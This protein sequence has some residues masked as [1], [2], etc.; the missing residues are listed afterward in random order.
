MDLK[1]IWDEWVLQL[2]RRFNKTKY[3]L[4]LR[5]YYLFA[6]T[7]VFMRVFLFW[8]PQN[9][10]DLYFLIVFTMAK[11]P[12]GVMFV[13]NNLVYLS[14]ELPWTHDPGGRIRI[15]AVYGIWALLPSIA[16]DRNRD[17]F[18]PILYFR[19]KHIKIHHCTY[20]ECFYWHELLSGDK[21]AAA[22]RLK[23]VSKCGIH[24]Q[25]GGGHNSDLRDSHEFIW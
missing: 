17:F 11:C 20:L 15:V 10:W 12:G 4:W 6:H 21:T 5:I 24:E 14:I 9:V 22:G 3:I 23:L 2:S 18:N 1:L 13:T 25:R 16:D 19:L 7:Q 8:S